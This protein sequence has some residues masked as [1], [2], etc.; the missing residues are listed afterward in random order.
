MVIITE[1]LRALGVYL[2][3]PASTPDVFLHQNQVRNGP[4]AGGRAEAGV[5]PAG[6]PEQPG[7]DW[8]ALPFLAALCPPEAEGHLL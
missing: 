3:I 8:E 6:S 1:R 7:C 5:Q 2:G 4:G